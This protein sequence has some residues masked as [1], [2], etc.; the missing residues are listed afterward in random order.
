MAVVVHPLPDVVLSRHAAE[1]DA[2]SR[3]RRRYQVLVTGAGHDQVG[4]DRIEIQIF[5]VVDDEAVLRIID[6]KALGHCFQSVHHARPCGF[7]DLRHLLAE[8]DAGGRGHQ[9]PHRFHHC[10]T[11]QAATPHF[12]GSRAR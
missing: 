3:H 6:R 9:F 10:A 12:D 7:G 2:S 4:D 11:R 5:P 1:Y 8:I